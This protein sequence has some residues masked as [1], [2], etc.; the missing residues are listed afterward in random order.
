MEIPQELRDSVEAQREHDFPTPPSVLFCDMEQDCTSPV[1]HI[2]SK[3][4]VYCAHHAIERR[5]SGYECTRKLRRWE[6]T[7]LQAGEPLA[8]YK[9]IAKGEL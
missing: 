6:L 4:Y 2:G 1:T 9:P 5:Q 8:S 3:G 7:Q